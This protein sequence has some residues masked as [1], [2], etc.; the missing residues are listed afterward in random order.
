MP[1]LVSG[2]GVSHLLTVAKLLSET[3][4][5]QAAAVLG[6][7][8]DWGIGDSIR[9]IMCFDTTSSNTGRIAGAY[10]LLE[11]KLEKE[12]LS[13]TSRHHSMELIIG[14]VFQVCMG[15]TTSSPEVRLFMRFQDYW[16]LIDTAK[17]ELGIAADDVT[18]L[19]ED[20]RQSIT[21]Y[22]NK[23]L[24]QSLS[25]D[26]YK[27][28]LELVIVFLGAAHAREVRFCSLGAMH[29][30]R[31]MS[32]VI[33]SL[34]IWMFKAQFKLTRTEERRLRDV[35]VCVCSQYVCTLKPGSLHLRDQVLLTVTCC[36]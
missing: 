11:Q 6:A 12:L 2:K 19:V 35:C 23:H 13:L 24:E 14:A 36:Y 29:H 21:D 22:A 4:E 31:W 7:I 18:D 16:R 32:K 9:A 30:T 20:I 8:Q 28:F 33:N 15:A 26:D 27:E 10:V 17:Y 1:V 5:S 25:R 3:G 34:T